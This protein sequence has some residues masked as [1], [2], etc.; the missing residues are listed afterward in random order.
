LPSS[1]PAEK[2]IRMPGRYATTQAFRSALDGKLR[3]QS[4]RDGTNLQRLQR[5]L[6]FERCLARLFADDQPLWILKGG[7]SLELR[8]H[9]V[10]RATVDLDLSVPLPN[11][12]IGSADDALNSMRER[13]QI[14]LERDLD[15]GFT[16]LLR[17]TQRPL[18]GPTYG[19]IRF[20]VEARLVGREFSNF[21]LDVAIGD[22]PIPEVEWITGNAFLNF[23]G[24][25]PA[26]IAILPIERHFA[27]KLHAYTLTRDGD[28]NSRIKDL[29]DLVLLIDVGL[30]ER[31][32]V[33]QAL[34]ATFGRRMTHELPE[35]L[36][37]PPAEWSA[38][39]AILAKGSGASKT[40][41]NNAHEY[42]VNY[43]AS[44][45]ARGQDAI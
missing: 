39:Y 3:Q 2:P 15:D 20:S 37:E 13:L 27:E 40:T 28:A 1:E 38:G 11:V 17:A 30:P 33:L 31:H 4:L 42:V 19:G 18:E 32:K 45:N 41:L 35:R 16:F 6:A 12:A 8:L 26:R 44:L 25:P 10:A 5:R 21:H 24:I 9:D 29:I 36:L 7:Y 14:A 23:A 34:N 22:A 43:Y